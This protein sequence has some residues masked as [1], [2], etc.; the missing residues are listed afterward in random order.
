MSKQNLRAHVV[1]DV[2]LRVSQQQQGAA[3]VAAVL[4]EACLAPS[5]AVLADFSTAARA[6]ALASS[7]S[8]QSSPPPF[9]RSPSS[10]QLIVDAMVKTSKSMRDE[11]EANE[12]TRCVSSFPAAATA[13]SLLSPSLS[14]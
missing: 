10:V 2:L 1:L 3:A 13:P 4:D 11:E 6:M 9:L 12:V 7:L 8:S 5:L 14:T